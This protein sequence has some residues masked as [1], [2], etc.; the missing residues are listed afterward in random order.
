MKYGKNQIYDL[1]KSST[2]LE[3]KKPPNYPWKEQLS[4]IT[5]PTALYNVYY[6]NMSN[7]IKPTALCNVYYQNMS[8]IIKLT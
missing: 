3:M 4:N 8:N 6:Q 1:R 7:I 2:M 5:K